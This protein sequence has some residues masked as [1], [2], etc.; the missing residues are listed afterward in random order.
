MGT[1]KRVYDS[2]DNLLQVLNKILD[3]DAVAEKVHGVDGTLDGD[4]FRVFSSNSTKEERAEALK[5]LSNKDFK[6][7]LPRQK[8]N[9]FSSEILA[10][11]EDRAFAH[12]T[13]KDEELNHSIMSAI[14]ISISEIA[15]SYTP[16]TSYDK[17]RPFIRRLRK[18]FT[19]EFSTCKESIVPIESEKEIEN[20][21]E[22]EILILLKDL[23]NAPYLNPLEKNI[24]NLHYHE[25]K[26][27]KE[28]ADEFD[29]KENTVR[30]H[31]HRA[32]KRI[33][34]NES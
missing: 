29:M 9:E 13:T 12:G 22:V 11:L 1:F 24:I 30:S 18:N 27:F 28:I 25:D 32:L 23:R 6:Y 3:F 8:W 15:D 16:F 10:E 21:L 34:E 4:I 31:H 19:A 5:R 17:I 20:S 2:S 14:N 33:K 26:S 7:P